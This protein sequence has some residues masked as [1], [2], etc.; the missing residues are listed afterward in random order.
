MANISNTPSSFSPPEQSCEVG[1]D[2]RVSDPIVVLRPGLLCIHQHQ[3]ARSS[4][5]I[6]NVYSFACCLYTDYLAMNLEV[7]NGDTLSCLVH[8]G[9][10]LGDH[11]PFPGEE[12]P[13]FITSPT[14]G[15]L[16]CKQLLVR[17]GLA[18]LLAVAILVLGILIHLLL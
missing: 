3:M 6:S 1:W 11:Q 4:V 10:N 8:P 13:Q 15:A 17:R 7:P 12:M 5:S 9:E 16:S 18:L 2:E 14:P